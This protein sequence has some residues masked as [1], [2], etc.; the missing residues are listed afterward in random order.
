MSYIEEKRKKEK[1]RRKRGFILLALFVF[2]VV[3][4]SVFSAFVPMESWKYYVSLPKVES[5]GEGELRIH[6]LD[7][8]QADA[9][10]VELPDGKTLLVDGGDVDGAEKVLRYLN[11]LK[12]DKIDYILLTHTDTDHCGSLADVVKYKEIGEVIYP[13][14]AAAATTNEAFNAFARELAGRNIETKIA[15][16]YDGFS[17]SVEE[18]DYQFTILFPYSAGSG[19]NSDFSGNAL[20]TVA[21]L[22]YKGVT[23]M[24]CGDTNARV[25]GRLCDE[26]EM[27]VFAEYEID[28]T[29]VE[30]LK[31]PHH[32]AKTGANKWILSY[33][34]VETSV[35]SCGKNNYYGHP[36]SEALTALTECLV[37]TYRTDL[38]G[39]ITVTIGGDGVYETNYG[40]KE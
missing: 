3:V 6:F 18:Y 20:S 16:R 40:E 34:N 5:R 11:A 8:G 31:Y 4:L 9:T 10:L 38:H 25:L 15:S 22:E 33:L 14:N 7:V 27:G 35:I 24:L 32:G 36:T 13:Y 1:S 28:L 21:L 2:L 37:A 29:S 19:G 39:T 12:I 17:S 30:I 23:T 26:A